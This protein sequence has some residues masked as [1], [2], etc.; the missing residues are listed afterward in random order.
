MSINQR[1][2]DNIGCQG[3]WAETILEGTLWCDVHDRAVADW[4]GCED[5]I[6]PCSIRVFGIQEG[7]E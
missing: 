5:V 3:V 6:S 1:H 4:N 2:T 7:V